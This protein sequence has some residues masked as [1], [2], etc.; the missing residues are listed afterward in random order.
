M[1]EINNKKLGL[2]SQKINCKRNL[3]IFGTNENKNNIPNF[4]GCSLHILC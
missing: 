3:K 4:M 1:Q 2:V